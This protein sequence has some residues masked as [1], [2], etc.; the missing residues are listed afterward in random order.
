MPVIEYA[1]VARN[2]TPTVSG[3]PDVVD[4]AGVS[5]AGKM[6]TTGAVVNEE[7]NGVA[8]SPSASAAVTAT[9]YSVPGV[10]SADGVNVPLVDVVARVPVTAVPAGSVTVMLILAVFTALLN[11]ARTVVMFDTP[12]APFAGVMA[13]TVGAVSVVKD[14]TTCVMGVPNGLEAPT[15]AV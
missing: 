10:S 1:T 9:P 11:V 2:F 12:V 4:D 6:F 13:D 15:L 14:Q 3:V 8:A 7:L 5:D